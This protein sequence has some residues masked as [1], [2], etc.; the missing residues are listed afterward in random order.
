MT[1]KN[2]VAGISPREALTR[3]LRTQMGIGNAPNAAA[4]TLFGAFENVS[5]RQF[6]ALACQAAADKCDMVMSIW[7]DAGSNAPSN[8]LVF[9][10][11]KG[12]V[13]LH[14]VDVASPQDDKALVLVS[15]DRASLFYMN[16]HNVMA[17]SR[18]STS[19][20]IEQAVKRGQAR[21][22]VALKAFEPVGDGGWETTIV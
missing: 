21:L 9:Y 22:A 6:I 20:G 2:T 12:N 7:K 19:D 8:L 11:S 14:P 1:I 18:C 13:E 3:T 5:D 15:Q 17:R 10:R 16:G 4:S